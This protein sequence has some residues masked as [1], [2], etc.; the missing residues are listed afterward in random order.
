MSES[1]GDQVGGPRSV[2]RL[3]PP[4]WCIPCHTPVLA[5]VSSGAN[6]RQNVVRRSAVSF[7]SEWTIPWEPRDQRVTTGWSGPAM[8][9]AAQ[10]WTLTGLTAGF[11]VERAMSGPLH[12]HFAS[13]R[14]RGGCKPDLPTLLR[15]Q[16]CRI[17][18]PAGYAQCLPIGSYSFRGE[19]SALD[20]GCGHGSGKPGSSGGWGGA[21]GVRGSRRD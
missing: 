12:V 18:Q 15:T 8:E 19:A 17:R 1:E 2:S 14:G 4:T 16:S 6:I 3:I 13:M 7:E 11:E 5:R 20:V 21:A 9:P 10:A